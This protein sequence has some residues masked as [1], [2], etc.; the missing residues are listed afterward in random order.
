MS[1]RF[2]LKGTSLDAHFSYNG[3]TGAPF[4]NIADD[5]VVTNNA[6]AGVFGGQVI[7]MIAASVTKGMIYPGILN[8][9]AL[10]N[11]GAFSMR[12]RIVPSATAAPFTGIGVQ[13][14]NAVGEHG[15][16]WRAGITSSGHPYIQIF[17]LA[18]NTTT[19]IGT[20]TINATINVPFDF[21]VSWDGTTTANAI[22]FSVDGVQ[23]ETLTAGIAHSAGRIIKACNSIIIGSVTAGATSIKASVNDCAIWDSAES[24]TYTARTDFDVVTAFDGLL[25]TSP[26]VASVLTGQTWYLEGVQQTGTM[27]IPTAPTAAVIAAAAWDELM[28]AHVTAG[29]FGAQVQKLLTLSKFLGLK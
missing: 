7:N 14:G 23:T 26:G 24:H 6:S 21:M 28:A 15:R 10:S 12:M 4:G 25:N 29:S 3:K 11:T 5:P 8:V 2:Y 19:H 27:S 18:G 22:K 13:V 1:L 17:D 16:G 9:G 20:S